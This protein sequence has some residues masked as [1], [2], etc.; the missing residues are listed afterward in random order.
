MIG[1]TISHY[2]ILEKLGGG[3]MGLV[4]KARDT[5]LDRDVALKVISTDLLKDAEAVGAFVREAKSASALNHPNIITVHDLLFEAE[6]AHFIVMEL[7]EGKTLRQLI[8]KKGVE[9]KQLFA[10]TSQVGEALSAA[11]NAGIVHRDLKPENVMVRSDGHVKVV[12]FGLAKLVAR[13]KETSFDGPTPNSTLPYIGMSGGPNEAPAE[14]THIA[15]TL[16]YMS[17]EQLRGD[18]VDQRSDIFSFGVVVYEMATGRQPFQ[19]RTTAEIITNILEVVPPPLTD[20]SGAFPE[21]LQDIVSKC[22]DKDPSE[23]YQHYSGRR[24]SDQAIS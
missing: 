10:I 8:R 2:R 19:G 15:G 1:K 21:K 20:L 6:G 13:K 9:P 24:I 11:H 4:F 14:K 22:L 23:R 7:V 17:P 12:D 3:G 16:P 5:L 18:T